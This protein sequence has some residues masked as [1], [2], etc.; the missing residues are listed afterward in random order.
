M[1][2]YC[3]RLGV[4]MMKCAKTLGEVQVSKQYGGRIKDMNKDLKQRI[5]ERKRRIYRDLY[6]C[7]F[8]GGMIAGMLFSIIC[9]LFL[10]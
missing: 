6:I 2:T 1:T 7:V 4:D 8:L 10:E 9:I 5:V 3:E